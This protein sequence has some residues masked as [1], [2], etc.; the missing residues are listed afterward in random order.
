MIFLCVVW[1]CGF[2]RG[3]ILGLLLFINSI[4]ATFKDIFAETILYLCSFVRFLFCFVF[5][6]NVGYFER[7]GL[8]LPRGP[9]SYYMA[10]DDFKFF[11]R[12]IT[13]VCMCMRSHAHT[14][15]VYGHVHHC[16]YV[17]VRRVL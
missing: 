1:V 15:M 8:M 3:A 11:F 5:G 13:F 14:L 7:Q 12:K 10:K 2:V 9:Q 4:Y 17:E 6:G 16:M